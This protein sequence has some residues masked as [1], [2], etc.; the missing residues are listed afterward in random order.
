MVAG[1]GDIDVASSIDGD[2]LGRVETRECTQSVEHAGYARSAGKGCGFPGGA[3]FADGVVARV[4]EVGVA[5]GIK[6]DALWRTKEGV[7]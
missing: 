7:P 5:C 6:R 4:G 2:A 1:V 3:D